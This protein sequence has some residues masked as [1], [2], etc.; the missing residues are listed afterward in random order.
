MIRSV[1]P[2]DNLVTEVRPLKSGHLRLFIQFDSVI[3]RP[4]ESIQVV[5]ERVS[6]ICTPEKKPVA[7][8]LPLSPVVDDAKDTPPVVGDTKQPI[9]TVAD[10]LGLKLP[11]NVILKRVSATPQIARDIGP[12]VRHTLTRIIEWC[13]DE[14]A[15]RNL[16]LEVKLSCVE[17]DD[18]ERGY[19]VR[20]GMRI[21]LPVGQGFIAY[22]QTNRIVSVCPRSNFGMEMWATKSGR[23]RLCIQFD[24]V[25]DR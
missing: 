7:V 15:R 3:D 11:A 18:N 21:R 22:Q 10:P 2:R 20:H 8:A 17:M 13:V 14:F 9:R 6:P 16:H 12:D 19:V 4:V 1:C 5:S 24:T 25:I 23:L